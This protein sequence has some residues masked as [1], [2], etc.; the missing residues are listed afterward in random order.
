MACW[1]EGA[2]GGAGG[3]CWH[4][5][6][7]LLPQR[8]LEPFSENRSNRGSGE[9]TCKGA[10]RGPLGAA[11]M[12]PTRRLRMD[13]QAHVPPPPHTTLQS[14]A[15]LGGLVGGGGTDSKL[16]F[17]KT[18]LAMAVEATGFLCT[19]VG[20]H[21]PGLQQAPPRRHARS[22]PHRPVSRMSQKLWT[23]RFSNI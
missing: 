18:P 6:P 12:Q 11:A 14:G 17:G 1:A 19:V 5:C 23:I 21:E 20:A 7:A 22:S 4:P 3:S 2:E 10:E 9:D 15:P 13:G 16:S 8:L